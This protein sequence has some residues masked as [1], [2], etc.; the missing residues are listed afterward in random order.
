MTLNA[1]GIGLD[2][3]AKG[4][5]GPAVPLSGDPNPTAIISA[6]THSRIERPQQDLRVI[7]ADRSNFLG[8]PKEPEPATLKGK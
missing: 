2:L 4:S 1:T 6:G 5:S 7:P 8:T 3:R